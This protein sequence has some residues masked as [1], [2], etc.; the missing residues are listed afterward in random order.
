MSLFLKTQTK[1]VATS[2][3]SSITQRLPAVFADADERQGVD[4]AQK[5][6]V[7]EVLEAS[8]TGATKP[9]AAAIEYRRRS[10]AFALPMVLW[11]IAF[12]T[13]L[14]LVA[15][16]AVSTWLDES[17]HAEKVFRARQ[18]ALSGVAIAMNIAVPPDDPLLTKG[19]P[20]T[21]QG[22][23]YTVE[24][25]NDGG[26]INPNLFLQSSDRSF[27]FQRLFT[28]WNVSEEDQEAASDGLYDWISPTD[29]RSPH[30]AKRAEYEA[31]GLEGFPPNTFLKDAGEMAM[32]IGFRPVIKAKPHW[33]NYFSTF[34][35]GKINVKA[36]PPEILVDLLG[37]TPEQ[38]DAW[39]KVCAGPDGIVG[40]ADDPPINSL[41]DAGK[42]M[43]LNDQQQIP[44]NRWFN[45]T[46][47]IRRIDST[48]N[49]YGVKHH[50][51]VIMRNA[52]SNAMLSWQEQ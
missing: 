44:L 13:A 31:I 40:T 7:H 42:L 21:N 26:L 28:A 36:A 38:A 11:T 51:I 43:G 19:D 25:T 12:L 32:V 9:F 24:I 14:I 34:N 29:L 27:F 6:S 52:T 5:V 17:T 45:L 41:Q 33:K 3:K 10:Q 46:S 23:G 15:V 4:G 2:V 30:G 39:I 8:S 18:Q 50:I 22:E 35:P 1:P 47:T 49:C 16:T 37:I 48:G 20:K